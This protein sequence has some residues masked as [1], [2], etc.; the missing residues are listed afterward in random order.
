MQVTPGIANRQS[1]ST[2]YKAIFQ[3]LEPHYPGQSHRP[4]THSMPLSPRTARVVDSNAIM[5]CRLRW[6]FPT[7]IVHLY[8]HVLASTLFCNR[9]VCSSRLVKIPV[10]RHRTKIEKMPLTSSTAHFRRPSTPRIQPRISHWDASRSSTT[11]L[12]LS[13]SPISTQLPSPALDSLHPGQSHQR[14]QRLHSSYL[15]LQ[16]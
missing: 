9:Q 16:P 7:I 2:M 1:E 15:P 12:R 11:G 10:N 6:I 4:N 5:S 13:T 8:N 14:I 3:P